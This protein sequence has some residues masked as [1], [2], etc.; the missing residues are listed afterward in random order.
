MT[1]T[2]PPIVVEGVTHRYGSRMPFRR[3]EG[4]AALD[5]LSLSLPP[6]G[7]VALLGANGAGKSTL[8]RILA[9]MQRPSR[10]EVR[11]L[12]HDPFR[13]AR[14]VRGRV[15]VAAEGLSLPPWMRLG[16]LERWLA[17]LYPGW[18]AGL[19]GELR[20]RFGLEPSR[21][22]G[23]LSRG[24]HRKAALLCAMAPRPRVLLL[25][26]PFGGVD[27]GTREA[28]ARGL[29]AAAGGE[30]WTVVVAS[31]EVTEME[32]LADHLVVL[33]RGKLRLHAPLEEVLARYRRVEVQLDDADGGIPAWVPPSALGA[34][35]SGRRLSFVVETGA[36][37]DLP[38]PAEIPREARA[39]AHRMGLRELYLTLA[40]EEAA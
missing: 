28:L 5:A 1:T 24:E 15:T 20:E 21:R 33:N 23:S 40:R 29:L 8:L 4:P 27:V 34:E 35:R 39:S 12:G 11:V 2:D 13:R 7:T 26:E 17:P 19:A 25:D 16:E 14:E 37:G 10:G 18:D 31:H 6:G 9:G 36:D 22:I 30:G 38:L 32:T 3:P